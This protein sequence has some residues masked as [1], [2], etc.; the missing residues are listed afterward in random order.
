MEFLK[1]KV[2]LRNFR[3]MVNAEKCKPPLIAI[4]IMAKP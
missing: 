2:K 1:A 4:H 3:K